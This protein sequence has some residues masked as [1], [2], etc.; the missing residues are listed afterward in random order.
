MGAGIKFGLPLSDAFDLVG[1][2]FNAYR[3]N[4]T[5]GPFVEIRLPLNLAIEFDALYESLRFDYSA[6]RSGLALENSTTRAASWQ[7]PL[8]LKYRFGSARVRPYVA[9]GVAAYYIGDIR[10][11]G[12]IITSLPE[13]VRTT[14]S[15]VGNSFANGGGVVGGGLEV[16]LGPLRIGPEIRFTRWAVEKSVGTSVVSLRLNQSQTHFLVSASF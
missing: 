2:S 7:F 14:L 11:T 16:R 3:P 15:R 4:Y 1:E 10:Q 6:G 9:G 5:I 13:D 8:L 12:E